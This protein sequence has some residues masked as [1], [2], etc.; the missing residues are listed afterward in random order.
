MALELFEIPPLEGSTK[1][2]APLADS[3]KIHVSLGRFQQNS[4][5]P[6][7]NDYLAGVFE[8]SFA[9][10]K[11][12]STIEKSLKPNFVWKYF[13]IFSLSL[14]R[15]GLPPE[16]HVTMVNSRSVC[17]MGFACKA[18]S[19][20]RISPIFHHLVSTALQNETVWISKRNKIIHLV[21]SKQNE[22]K[23]KQFC[24]EAK[25]N[26][27]IFSFRTPLIIH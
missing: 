10:A 21:N 11:R 23:T 8:T 14:I 6:L 9:G 3:T 26:F 16:I 27:K 24:V 15:H 4:Y 20:Y 12:N 25:Q 2:R 5:A 13:E 1:P 17:T 22:T 18:C 7:K 19:S